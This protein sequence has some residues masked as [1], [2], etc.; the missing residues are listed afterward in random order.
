MMGGARE[1]V[2][3]RFMDDSNALHHVSSIVAGLEEELLAVVADIQEARDM[4]PVDVPD[5]AERSDVLQDLVRAN[6]SG[7]LSE[8]YVEA[9]LPEHVDNADKAAGYLGLDDQ[10][11][12]EQMDAWATQY[13]LES[14]EDYTSRD[15]ARHHVDKMF[16]VSL[17]EFESNV[18]DWNPG[19][20]LQAGL[21]GNM[22]SAIDALREVRDDL[23]EGSDDDPGDADPDD[24]QDDEGGDD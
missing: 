12:D 4:E 7:N 6:F 16:G 2:I 13:G 11:W 22:S 10:D 14:N 23:Q 1:K 8:W 15:V 3:K 24:D 20:C 5:Q 19:Q 17:E 21:A 18:V 9:V